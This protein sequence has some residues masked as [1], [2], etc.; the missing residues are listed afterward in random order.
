ML[1]IFNDNAF[2]T[3]ALTEA[4]NLLPYRL[5]RLGAMGLFQVKPA[6][7]NTVIIERKGNR[8]AILESKPRGS[9]ET[10][11]SPATRRDIVPILIPYIPLDDAVLASDVSGVRAFGEENA[12]EAVSQIT[13][14][15]LQHLRELHETTHEW[16]R[17]GAIKGQILDGDEAFSELL[18]LFDVFNVPQTEIGFDLADVSNTGFK[19]AC[20]EVIGIIEEALGGMTYD[21]V[22][23]LVGNDFFQDLVNHPAVAGAYTQPN[24]PTNQFK[25]EQQSAYGTMGRG[26]N[27]V[28]FGDIIFENYRGKVAGRH[29]IEPDEAHF[30]PV[31]VPGLF[32]THFAPANTIS[33]V[34]QAG[35]N[36]YVMQ[37][38]MKFD[39]GI[40][41]HSESNPL[42]ICTMPEVLVHGYAGAS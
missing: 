16:H 37:E 26:T 30:F 33:G 6:R 40:E 22:H 25:V 32:Q 8:L 31:G 21:H 36:I 18:D 24:H 41:L 4:I 1:D 5:R 38:K 35:R 3:H 15:K 27:Q 42:C 12:L 39:A 20:A 28:M 7:T 23:A 14:E 9:G 34:N 17:I 19:A 11:K 2:S 29:F 13:N 10:N